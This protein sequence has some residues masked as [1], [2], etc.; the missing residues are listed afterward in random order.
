MV[1]DTQLKKNR[2]IIQEIISTRMNSLISAHLISKSKEIYYLQQISDINTKSDNLTVYPTIGLLYQL[3]QQE[4]SNKTKNS[5]SDKILLYTPDKSITDILSEMNLLN[6]LLKTKD[7]SFLQELFIFHLK[8]VE[9]NID[10]LKSIEIKEN[11]ILN[12]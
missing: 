9:Q 1:D 5:K 7:L 6:E 10:F 12:I 8:N 2:T 11:R 4:Q 3:L